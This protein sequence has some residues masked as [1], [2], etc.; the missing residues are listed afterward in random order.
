MNERRMMFILSFPLVV[1]LVILFLG[2]LRALI[3]QDFLWAAG[4]AVGTA[5]LGALVR[6]IYRNLG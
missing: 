2:M 6:M 3:G 1:A 5:T 4:F